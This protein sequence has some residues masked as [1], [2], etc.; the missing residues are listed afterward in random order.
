[1]KRKQGRRG[2]RI[3]PRFLILLVVAAVVVLGVRAALGNHP[4]TPLSPG[5]LLSERAK[6]NAPKKKPKPFVWHWAAGPSLPAPVE[7]LT[8]TVGD[9]DLL[10]AGGTT[11]AGS[12]S[13][14][15]A[16][17][18]KAVSASLPT[19]VHDAASAV[20]D[21]TL[22]VF[23]GGTTVAIPNIQ[24]ISLTGQAATTPRPLPEPLS[25]LSAV[26]HGGFV[27]LV[28]GFTGS[29]WSDQVWRWNPQQGLSALGTLPTGLRY[30]GVA[31]YHGEI[32]V[33]GGL[34]ASSSYSDAVYAVNP[35]TGRV[36]DLPPLPVSVAYP[37]LAIWRGAPYLAG[38]LTV[39][40][41]TDAVWRYS[42]PAT[43]WVAVRHLP[44][45]TYYGAL[46]TYKNQ[47]WY[48]GGSTTV[49]SA[50]ITG[51]IWKTTP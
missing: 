24:A 51:R 23:G 32:L 49:S 42:G 4:T 46:V 19:P 12:V 20:M 27:Y 33:A 26:V 15:T 35:K 48:I 30:A 2:R 38:G 36:R 37:A 17:G 28:G 39:S 18:P 5:S 50:G 31:W 41:P 11:S 25:D 6:G 21:H 13:T 7:G 16:F 45:S 3:R 1:M 43:G 14:I 40:G 34:T 10:V 9:G 44:V 8:A 47:L 29:A 22:Y